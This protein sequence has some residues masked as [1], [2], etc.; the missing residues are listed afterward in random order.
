MAQ[1]SEIQPS[2]HDLAL[3][4][5]ACPDGPLRAEVC[6]PEHLAEIARAIAADSTLGAQRAGQPLLRR[7]QGNGRILADTYRKLA[8]SAQNDE[9][10]TTDAEWLLDNYYI[11]EDVLREVRVD[12]PRGYYVELP[13]LGRG[14]L[15]GQPR[16]YAL[17]VALIAHTDSSFDETQLLDFVRSYQAVTP[18]TL[19]ELW[20]V[21]TMLRVALIENL[22]RLATQMLQA[23]SDIVTAETLVAR[24]HA[25]VPVSAVALPDSPRGTFLV[26]LLHALRDHT[27]AGRAGE[28]LHGWLTHHGQS[29]AE[30]FRREHQ[31]QATNQIS[32]GNCVTSLRF[33]SVLD[34]NTF[35]EKTSVVEAVLRREPTGV[36]AHQDFKT[37]DRYR[38]AIERLARGSRRNETDVAARVVARATAASGDVRKGHVG[39]HLIGEGERSFAAELGYRPRFGDRWPAWLTRRPNITYFVPITLITGGVIALAMYLAGVSSVWAGVAILFVLLLPASE[40]AVGLTNHFIC[41]LLPPRVLP[42]LDFKDGI[43]SDCA[44]FVVIPSMLIRQES[45]KQLLDQLELHYL[46]NP[47]PQLWFALLTD[48]ADAPNENMPED[49]RYISAALDGVRRL[50]QR[51]AA[52]GPDR[53]FVLHRRRQWNPVEGRWMGWE[54]KRGKLQEF[55]R[56]LRGAK[57]TSF[58]FPSG[59][60]PRLPQVRYVLT[61]DADTVLPRE[62]ARQL[63]STLAHPLN[64]AIRS[65]DGRRIVAGYGVLQPR[66]SFLYRVGLRSRFGRIYAGSAGID[67]Y[68]SASSD[69]YQDLFGRGSYTGKGLYD[70][71]AFEETAGAAFP[72]NHILSHDL[73]EANFARCALVTDIEFFDDFPA[74]YHAYAG[75]AHR[76]VRGDWQLLPWLGRKVPVPN[77]PRRPNV[78][79][80]LERWKVVDNLRRSVVPPALLLLL[81]AGWTILPGAAWAWT[82]LVVLILALPLTL[83]LLDGIRGSLR[84]GPSLSALRQARITLGA[85]AVQGFLALVFLAHQT[86]VNCDAI[87]RTLYRLFI[88]RRHLLEWEAAA[89]T[90]KRLGGEFMSFVATMWPAWAITLLVALAVSLT[91]PAALVLAIP[92]MIL[93]LLSPVVAYF[94]SQPLTSHEVELNEAEEDDLRRV[95]QDL[96]IF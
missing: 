25:D 95:A 68:S 28:H 21:P 56:L 9:S 16:I 44:T 70:V 26:A 89:A 62:A 47:D 82:L 53:F 78:L 83:Q 7:F 27:P 84:H 8:T 66:V 19:G 59:E 55:N 3:A 51:Y 43:P 50:N 96:G 18:L 22:A 4:C 2:A 14:I 36:Y 93:W 87:V 46:A 69:V 52:D 32:V 31:R 81:V 75:R 48:F 86:V 85:T 60:A 61:L 57:D 5:L 58:V 91:N 38:H 30:V 17:A 92:F 23:R 90:E 11:I 41:W 29:A 10:I 35:V 74:R 6:G 34:W 79:P 54:R 13:A 76:W 40:L 42:K 1:T 88:S 20:A 49:E 64:R 65:T 39:W 45:A 71:G 24:A 94:V 15:A 37:R 73:I 72:E 67:P 80:L 63:V 77:G 12:L 33:L